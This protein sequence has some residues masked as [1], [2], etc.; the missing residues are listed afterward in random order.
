MREINLLPPA[1]RASLRREA[2]TVALSHL[3]NSWIAGLTIAASAAV[4]IGGSVWTLSYLQPEATE[5]AL[6]AEVAKYQKMRTEVGTT[7]FFLEELNMLG[8]ERLVWSEFMS[9]LLAATPTG[10]QVRSV[11]GTTLTSDEQKQRQL[12]LNGRAEARGSLTLFQDRLRV[13]PGVS[14]V[15]APSSNFL[16]RDNP[17]FQFNLKLD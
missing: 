8:K 16:Q 17:T 4:L 2:I 13:V 12:T 5:A 15:D 14:A 1:R 6:A 10:V 9:Q 7:N 11:T 3:L